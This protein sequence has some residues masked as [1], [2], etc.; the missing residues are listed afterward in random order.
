MT[1]S[2]DT[3]PS[4]GG[5]LFAADSSAN[6][7]PYDGVVNYFGPVMSSTEADHYLSA[8]QANVQW[9]HDELVIFGRH[10]VTA[11]EVAWFGDAGCAYTYSGTTKQAVP[12][13]AEL[14]ALKAL[15]EKLT[16]T[17]YNSCLANL[18]HDGSEGMAWHSDDEKELAPCATIASFSLGAERKFN[19]KHKRT[20]ATTSVTLEHGSLLAMRDTT[21]LHWLHSLPKA[22]KI[23]IPRINLTFRTILPQ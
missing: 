8:L 17:T 5:D 22:K 6:L 14:R 13:N 12:W 4:L 1:P 18:Y 2:P 19:F 3:S 9:K 11:R 15:V 20:Q 10:I 23:T 16:Q 21:Q 7:L